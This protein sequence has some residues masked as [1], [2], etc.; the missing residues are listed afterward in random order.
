MFVRSYIHGEASCQC[1]PSST[2]VF[3]EIKLFHLP[4]LSGKNKKSQTPIISVLGTNVKIIRGTTQV[5]IA[6]GQY[7]LLRILIICRRGITDAVCRRLLLIGEEILRSVALISPFTAP[8][9][10]AIPPSA[11]LCAGLLA[12]TLLIH[13][14][15]YDDMGIITL[16]RR[17]VK[18][19]CKNCFNNGGKFCRE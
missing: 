4:L 3:G 9:P 17:F 11:V 14:F 18:D 12:G 13:R 10:T 2:G 19:F 5:D 1:L 8:F 6:Y 15:W 16:A 7:P